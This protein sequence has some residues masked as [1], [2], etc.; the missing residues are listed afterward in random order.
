MENWYLVWALRMSGNSVTGDGEREVQGMT[1]EAWAQTYLGQTCWERSEV[2]TV[3]SQGPWMRPRM[4]PREEVL[5]PCREW[6]LT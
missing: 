5:P 3:P 1:E 4:D 6:T 2:E